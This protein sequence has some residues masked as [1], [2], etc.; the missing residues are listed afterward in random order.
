MYVEICV[1][2]VLRNCTHIIVLR[3]EDVSVEVVSG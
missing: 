1:D 3:V 2:T